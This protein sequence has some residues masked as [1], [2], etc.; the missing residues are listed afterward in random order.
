MERRL[1]KNRAKR[2]IREQSIQERVELNY[3]IKG[4]LH[5][6][7]IYDTDSI[8]SQSSSN[9]NNT[10]TNNHHYLYAVKV[11][12]DETLRDELRLNGREKRGRAFLQAGTNSVTTL[13][14]LKD[15]LHAFFRALKK[16]TFL[17][18]ATLPPIVPPPT[19]TTTPP[20]SND[21]TAA[22]ESS[23]TVVQPTVE[24]P[25]E[26]SWT[27]ESDDDVVKTFQWADTF[28]QQHLNQLKR[29]T[30]QI[31]VLKD[32]NAPPPPPTPL[33]LEGMKD[34]STTP[35]MTMISFYAFPPQGIP[36]PEEFAVDL[37]KKWKPFQALGRVYVA[38]EGVNAQM[39]VPTNVL[40]NFM[41]CCRSIPELGNYMEN[42]INI[43]PKPLTL[44]EFAVAGVPINGQ[45]AAPFRNLHVRVRTQVVA[46]GLDKALDWQSA[47]YDCPPHEWHEALK[48]ARALRKAG[49]ASEAPILLDCRNAY[50]TDIG[51]FDGAEPLNTQAFRESWDVLKDRLAD[52]PKDAPIMTYC[53]G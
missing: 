8:H 45:P 17:L 44:D 28:F 41:E 9:N 6:H 7:N 39:S 15:E 12:V 19:T 14:G 11:W 48:R 35:T 27:I 4:L 21:D 51:I 22:E 49:R 38:Q 1:E 33:Y 30:I 47:G 3:K 36:D 18:T 26:S 31:N 52:I 50:E 25:M 13:R 24:H 20:T 42:D 5:N 37:R 46:D 43:D 34:P 53:T 32:P 40:D 29:P 23:T 16:D 2:Q 10:T